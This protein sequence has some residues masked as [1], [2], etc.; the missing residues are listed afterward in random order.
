MVVR[1][2]PSRGRM[3]GFSVVKDRRMMDPP[4]ILQ[5]VANDGPNTHKTGPAFG[6]HTMVHI[7]LWST[8]CKTDCSVV[9]NPR[10]KSQGSKLRELV[11]M[12]PGLNKLVTFDPE[13]NRHCQTIL[14]TTS[15]TAVPLSDIDGSEGHFFIFP[16]LSVRIQGTYVIKCQLMELD[17][18]GSMSFNVT[19][20]IITQ[21][22]H[23]YPPKTFPRML[24]STDLSKC[25]ARQG[26]PFHIR[27]DYSDVKEVEES[28]DGSNSSSSTGPSASR[29]HLVST[30]RH[31]SSQGTAPRAHP[32]AN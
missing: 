24:D 6:Q 26:V 10:H 17:L 8:D 16:D 21:P 15:A 2:Q 20:T 30:A 9:V 32:Y 1:Q 4:L 12:T 11:E 28:K 22:F 19:K 13:A 29:R 18:E 23:M 7:S 3:C 5:L 25:F 27:R 14:G 31:S